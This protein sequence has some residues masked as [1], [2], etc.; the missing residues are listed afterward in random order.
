MPNVASLLR[1]EITRLSR[2]EIRRETQHTKKM[3]AQHRRYIA[4]LNRKISELERTLARLVRQASGPASSAGRPSSNGS[5]PPT[6]RFVAKG[7]RSHRNRLGLSASDF[8]KL[9]G[10]SSNSVYAWESGASTLRSQ[11]VV[12]IAELRGIGKREALHRLQATRATKSRSR[13]K[14]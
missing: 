3:T 8:G 2:R 14:R 9:L 4:A 11:Q 7:L 1:E 5:S 10:V 12:K 13:G 6:L